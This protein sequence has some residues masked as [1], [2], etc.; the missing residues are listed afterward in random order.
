MNTTY[1]N[2]ALIEFTMKADMEDHIGD[3]KYL[4]WFNTSEESRYQFGYHNKQLTATSPH[5]FSVIRKMLLNSKY[6]KKLH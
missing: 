5:D 6:F 4:Y 3:D 1:R 2:Q